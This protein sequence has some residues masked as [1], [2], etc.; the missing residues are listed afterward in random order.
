VNSAWI[1][2]TIAALRDDGGRVTDQRRLILAAIDASPAGISA[3]ELVASVRE[4]SGDASRSTVYRTLDLLRDIDAVETVHPSPEQHRYLARRSPDQH[5]V[6]CQTCGTVEIIERC[7]FD[8]ITSEVEL[9]TGFEVTGHS[10]EV[11]G[12]CG[13]C[14]DDTA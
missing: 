5:H 10:L 12:L 2:R 1:D 6:V 7:T 8:A 11:F 4:S 14:H 9:Q 3:E 13:P